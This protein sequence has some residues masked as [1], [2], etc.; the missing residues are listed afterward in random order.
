MD[1]IGGSSLFLRGRTEGSEGHS[2]SR[3]AGGWTLDRQ[4]CPRD[5]QEVVNHEARKRE[6]IYSSRG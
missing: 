4:R 5:L 1:D 6:C 3:G 2:S